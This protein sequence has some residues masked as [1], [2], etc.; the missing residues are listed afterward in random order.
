MPI[1]TETRILQMY[2]N[3]AGQ[4][5]PSLYIKGRYPFVMCSEK[6]EISTEYS[7]CPETQNRMVFSSKG[8]GSDGLWVR[9]LWLYN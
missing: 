7:P 5:M 6:H 1:A 4:P 3:D 2:G 8:V 9:P